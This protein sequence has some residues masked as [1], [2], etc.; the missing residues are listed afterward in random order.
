MPPSSAIE[1]LEAGFVRRPW[2]M[3]LFVVSLQGGVMRTDTV[4][5]EWNK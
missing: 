5:V 1:V 2:G 4:P 3:C